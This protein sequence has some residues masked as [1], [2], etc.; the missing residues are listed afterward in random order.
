PSPCPVWTPS[1]SWQPLPSG[2]TGSR[3]GTAVVPLPFRGPFQLA[4]A[5]I[6]VDVLSNGRF[7]LG[8]GIGGPG[9]GEALGRQ[10]ACSG[11]DRLEP[12]GPKK[13]GNDAR[14]S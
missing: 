8:E 4:K 3:L 9:A 12:S 1:Y 6:S 2:P 13:G 14:T 10:D 11:P 7:T 5:A